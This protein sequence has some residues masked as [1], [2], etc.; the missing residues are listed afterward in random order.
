MGTARHSIELSRHRCRTCSPG[1][2]FSGQASL[3][4]LIKLAFITR[5]VRCV[6]TFHNYLGHLR[7]A[8]HAL[9]IEAPP[10]GHAA[11]KRAS[12]SIIKRGQF[13]AR[14]KMFIDRVMVSN[15]MK[16]VRRELEDLLYAMPWLFSYSFL[17]R[18]PSEVSVH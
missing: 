1:Q 17:L 18:L 4:A 15:M 12:I 6:D 14:P 11:V 8:C 2:T 13:E 5:F 3:K 10:T 7:S 16:A 9:N